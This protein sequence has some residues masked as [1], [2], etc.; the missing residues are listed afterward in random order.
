ME[1]SA[2]LEAPVPGPKGVVESLAFTQVACI[3]HGVMPKVTRSFLGNRD[4]MPGSQGDAVTARGKK[5][6]QG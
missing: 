4:R 3:F 1:A 2:F 5:N 6:Q